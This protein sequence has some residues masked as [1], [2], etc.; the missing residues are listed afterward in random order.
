M[1]DHKKC[2]TCKM[3]KGLHS[4]YNSKRELDGKEYQCKEC[5]SSRQKRQR[6]VLWM[7]IKEHYGFICF[8]CGDA[9]NEFLTID[10]IFND[11]AEQRRSLNK[12]RLYASIVR[13]GFPNTYRIACMNCNF[14]LGVR[15]YCPHKS[16]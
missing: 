14:S 16:K 2:S 12:G 7:K 1:N 15:G 6:E 13:D 4:F 9:T 3:I 10:H 8:C 5:S 11:G